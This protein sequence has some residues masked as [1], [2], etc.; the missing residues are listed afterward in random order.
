MATTHWGAVSEQAGRIRE[1]E[2][3]TEFWSET[4]ANGAGYKR[5][6]TRQNARGIIE[7][8]LA[9]QSEAVPTRIQEELVDFNMRVR[10]T[11]AGT[12]LYD[13]VQRRLG[14]VPPS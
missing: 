5:I 11:E 14:P 8:M 4:L 10:Q 9:K 3:R 13:A 7:Y 2:L 1:Q 6:Q 12:R